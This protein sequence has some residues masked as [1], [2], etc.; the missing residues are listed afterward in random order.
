MK[1]YQKTG[2]IIA[3]LILFFPAG[4]FLMWKYTSWNNI[5]K[6]VASVF[7]GII[8]I[9]AVVG[10]STDQQVPNDKVVTEQEKEAE[11]KEEVKEVE[12]VIAEEDLTEEEKMQAKFKD[13]EIEI[14]GSILYLKADSSYSSRKAYKT[15]LREDANRLHPFLDGLPQEIDTVCFWYNTKFMDKLGNESIDTVYRVNISIETLNKVNW[16]NFLLIEFEDLAED[17]FAHQ[18]IRN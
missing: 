8:F 9:I 2:W 1:W 10:A 17:V 4:A 11:T 13:Y 6:W 5:I 7:F 3:L 14:T 12:G 16:D 18:A 15:L